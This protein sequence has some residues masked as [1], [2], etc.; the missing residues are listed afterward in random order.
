MKAGLVT[1]AGRAALLTCSPSSPGVVAPSC[2]RL[3]HSMTRGRGGGGG[4]RAN[5]KKHRPAFWERF[6]VLEVAKPVLPDI[7]PTNTAELWRACPKEEDDKWYIDKFFKPNSL[8]VLFGQ[9][10]R[11]YLEQSPMVAVFQGNSMNHFN[12]RKNFQ[13]ARRV[14]FEY[15]SYS[16]N[17]TQDVLIG[18]KWENLAHFTSGSINECHF[19]FT[20]QMDRHSNILPDDVRLEPR[21]KDLLTFIKKSSDLLFLCAV[22]HGR[23]IDKNQLTKLAGMPGIDTLR[24]ELSAILQSPAR[25]TAQLLGASQ[26]KLSIQLDQY[27]KDKSDDSP[28]N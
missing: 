10:L 8:D 19:V 24:A 13:N 15:K 3:L 6:E 12:Q 14:N 2:V 28:Q 20:R 18:S 4:R 22:V 5:T 26:Q 25:K 7:E 23:I 11:Q 17:T 27:V 9:E 1:T 16:K 21:A